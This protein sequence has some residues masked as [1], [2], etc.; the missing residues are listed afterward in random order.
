QQQ[1]AARFDRPW[2]WLVLPSMLFASA[3]YTPELPPVEATHYMIWAFCFGLAAADLTARSGTLGPAIGFHLVN[4]ALAFLV[5][6]QAGG[7]DSGLALFL[8]PA[9][10][11]QSLLPPPTMPHPMPP[12]DMAPV[13]L[14]DPGFLIELLGIGLL[15]IGARIAIRR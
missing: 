12:E 8:F 4:N 11:A 13:S 7:M 6:G 15:W 5:F 9:D 14:F 2:V 1:L 3:H 10:P